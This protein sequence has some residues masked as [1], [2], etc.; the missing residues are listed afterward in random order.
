MRVNRQKILELVLPT[1]ALFLALLGWEF[2]VWAEA[3]PPYV[4]PSPSLILITL[5]KDWWTLSR[6][7]LVT[8]HITFEALGLAAVGRRRAGGAVRP[9]AHRRA[10]VLSLRGDPAG[11]ADRR[12]R[13]AAADLSQRQHRRAGLRVSRRVLSDPV[14]HRPRPRLGRSQPARS[15]P[16]LSRV[17][18]AAAAVAAPALG[19]AVFSRRLAD[20]R[21]ARADRRDRRGDRGGLGG[22]GR[23]PRL[24]DRRIRLFASI[25][26]A[27]S[28]RCC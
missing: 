26:R 19:V 22:P 8:L 5:V 27:C 12:D 2:V 23:G 3:I 25:F 14:E 16:A 24:S 9:I 28:R 20:R 1:L 13:A 18:L 6:S 10:R 11:D 17:A 7:L 4:L 15:L 21:R